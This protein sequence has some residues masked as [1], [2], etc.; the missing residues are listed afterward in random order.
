VNEANEETSFPPARLDRR[1]SVRYRLPHGPPVQV[2]AS[3]A[4]RRW[5]P[6]RLVD[7]S[8]GGFGLRLDE[9]LGL[10]TVVQVRVQG[11]PGRPLLVLVRHVTREGDGWRCGGSLLVRLT[12]AELEAL[13]RLVRRQAGAGF[14]EA[15]S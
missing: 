6:A 4:W 5:W 12:D 9:P 7:V 11:W 14:G 3:S 10:E 2:N 8:R 13:L 15:D 1:A